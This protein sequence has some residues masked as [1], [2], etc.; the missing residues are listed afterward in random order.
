M[1]IK[2]NKKIT[3]ND[4]ILKFSMAQSPLGFPWASLPQFEQL[5]YLEPFN[6][7]SLLK[8]IAV[9]SL[10]VLNFW[11]LKSMIDLYN[12]TLPSNIH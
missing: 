5:S 9:W 1:K 7:S 3:V 6:L 4:E 12:V 2:K 8:V 10:F 11:N